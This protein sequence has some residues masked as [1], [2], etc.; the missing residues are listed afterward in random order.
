[1]C[2]SAYLKLLLSLA[3]A[4]KFAKGNEGNVM[5]CFQISF[6]TISEF[7]YIFRIYRFT[8]IK[9]CKIHYHAGCGYHYETFFNTREIR[10]GRNDEYAVDM[11]LFISGSRD[12]QIF[13]GSVS[14][15]EIGTDHYEIG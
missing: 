6:L 2:A 4:S 8:E 11:K 10:S 5:I 1:M 15:P 14:D 13:L 12:A 3:L 9:N 7:K